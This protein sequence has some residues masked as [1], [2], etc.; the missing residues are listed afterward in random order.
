MELIH[1]D[2]QYPVVDAS[3]V[4]NSPTSIYDEVF[5][6]RNRYES[7]AKGPDVKSVTADTSAVNAMRKN[8]EICLWLGAE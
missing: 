7:P 2:R 3:S 1:V 4:L 5:L 8:S 6:P